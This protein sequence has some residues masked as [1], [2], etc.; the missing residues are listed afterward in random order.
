MTRPDLKPTRGASR[1]AWFVLAAVAAI[2]LIVVACAEEDDGGGSGGGGGLPPRGPLP[3]QIAFLDEAWD[4]E[5]VATGLSVPVKMA[6]APDGRLFVNLLGGTTLVIEAAPPYTQHI[7]ATEPVLNGPE[8]GLLGI[9]LSPDFATDGHVYVMACVNDMGDKQQIIRYTDVANVGTARTVIIDNL[10]IDQLH[11]A[12]AIKFGLDG[13]LFVSVGDAA[14][15]LNSQTDGSLAGRILR[16]TPAGGI[17]ADNPYFGTPDD[18]EWARGLRNSFGMC[19]HPTV[20]T[21]LITENGPNSDDELNYVTP[22][23]NFEWGAT[24]QIPGAQIGV[25]LRNWASVIV[26]T[27]LTYHSGNGA[28]AYTDNLFLCS[29]DLEQVQ[30]FEMDGAIPVN[31]LSENVFLEFVPMAQANKPLDIIEGIDGS[32]YISTFDAVWRV[33]PR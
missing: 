1:R 10:P 6:Q 22:G 20:G 32:L 24:R 19:V 12:G 9:A 2:A 26:P 16:Y 14:N 17:P 21:L 8:Q 18:A 11:N 27:G 3:A 29:Y 23:K 5:A 31:I 15:D 33:F 30:R 7:F 4:I 13:N 28:A 25:R